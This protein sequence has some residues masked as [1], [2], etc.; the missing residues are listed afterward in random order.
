MLSGEKGGE[1]TN[2]QSEDGKPYEKNGLAKDGDDEI[3]MLYLMFTF[4]SLTVAPL[5]PF[6]H[7]PWIAVELGGAVDEGNVDLA[8]VLKVT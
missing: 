5:L 6:F 4:G 3:H 2:D 7:R 8:E 1:V